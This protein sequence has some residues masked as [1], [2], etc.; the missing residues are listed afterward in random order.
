[1]K[2]QLER[3]WQLGKLAKDMASLRYQR[4]GPGAFDAQQRVIERLGTL[5]GLPQK[6]GQVLSL[7]ELSSSDQQFTQL[8]EGRATLDHCDVTTIIENETGGSLEDSFRR[9]D[10]NGI[11]ASIGQ[12]HRAILH[13]GRHV[14]IKVQYP[15]V[16]EAVATDLR[17]LGWLT[18][19]VGGLRRGFDLAGYQREVGQMMDEE[20]DYVH[21]AAMLRQFREW[22]SEWK[23]VVV[24]E[25]IDRLSTDRVLT[26]TWIEGESFQ[27]ARCWPLADRRRLADL[28]LRLFLKSCFEW[29]CLHADP[30]P[31]NYRFMRSEGRV[32]VGLIDF[33]CVKKFEKEFAGAFAG[34]ISHVVENRSNSSADF[35]LE[36]LV[37]M[38]FKRELL[39][40]LA[41]LLAPLSDVL[42]EPFTVSSNF[43]TTVWNL[44]ERVESVLGEFRWNFRIAGPPEMIYF[45]RAFQGLIQYLKAL[46]APVNWR[47]A[48]KESFARAEKVEEVRWA[49]HSTESSNMKSKSL[50]ILVT[51]NN[52]TRVK[53]T[54]GARSA[55]NL[56]DLVPDELV[57]KLNRRS[58]DL[59]LLAKRAEES[60][61]APAELFT[62]VE[63]SKSVRVWL[64]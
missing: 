42:F 11:S 52:E 4:S 55:A 64:E 18:A 54:F 32:S 14:A 12:V 63:G 27:M 61:F 22:T 7:S 53:L 34:L 51:E 39:N 20:L 37:T 16:A 58:I 19:P 25:V 6:I 13:D 49:R 21:E 26:M 41:H 48:L 31:G 38:G 2:K 24:P 57:G 3:S 9:I 23:D 33:G 35:V 29:N 17:A 36:S 1:V 44:G 43:D 28:L 10:P 50:F 46:D 62:L 8:T 15:F 60:D 47:E 5:H 45:M 30:H 56:P 40:P 59:Q